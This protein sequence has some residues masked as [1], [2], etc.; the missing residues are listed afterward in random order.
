MKRLIFLALIVLTGC[1]RYEDVYGVRQTVPDSLKVKRQEWITKTVSAASLHM[2]GG[3]YED[4]EDLIEE[5]T[6]Q[7]VSL[8]SVEEEGIR[9]IEYDILGL[10]AGDDFKP[11]KYF[12]KED[13]ILFIQ[14]KNKRR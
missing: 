3:D 2:T 10:Y 6:E 12:T 9:T 11:A 8:F 14:L 1:G 5:V 13:S 4:P 7:S